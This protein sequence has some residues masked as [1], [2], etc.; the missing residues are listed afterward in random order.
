MLVSK[1][2][3]ICQIIFENKISSY[4]DSIKLE[5]RELLKT[6][7]NKTLSILSDQIDEYFSKR[8]SFFNIKQHISKQHISTKNQIKEQVLKEQIYE[9]ETGKKFD[10]RMRLEIF[11]DLRKM[12]NKIQVTVSPNNHVNKKRALMSIIQII[13]NFPISHPSKR[14]RIIIEGDDSISSV[15]FSIK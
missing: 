7:T 8:R 10:K 9:N 4:I 14:T 12:N 3:R 11:E 6:K 15:N 13:R 5:N 2:D 1:N